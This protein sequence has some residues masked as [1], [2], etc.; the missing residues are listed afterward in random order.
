MNNTNN[1]HR[2]TV[3]LIIICF[4]SWISCILC[5]PEKIYA[6][7][8]TL[9][10]LQC[11]TPEF[12]PYLEKGKFSYFLNQTGKVTAEIQNMDFNLIRKLQFMKMEKAGENVIFWDGK[13][14]EGGIIEDGEYILALNAMDEMGSSVAASINMKITLDA[15]MGTKF[16][17][18]VNRIE[19]KEKKEYP[20]EISTKLRVNDVSDTCIGGV[21]LIIGAAIWVIILPYNFF[22]YIANIFNQNKNEKKER[23]SGDISNLLGLKEMPDHKKYQ[24]IKNKIDEYN[25]GID[26]EIKKKNHEIDIYNEKLKKSIIIKIYLID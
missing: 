18:H 19:G 20:K 2:K 16:K 11:K 5:Y 1:K 7:S 21:S 23:R 9:S 17:K 13:E 15:P 6:E 25:A 26:A 14:E 4:F 8:L 3:S 24:E 22:A 10:G 12:K